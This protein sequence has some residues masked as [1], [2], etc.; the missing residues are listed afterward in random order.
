MIQFLRTFSFSVL[1][2]SILAF[3]QISCDSYE[4]RSLLYQVLRKL[5]FRVGKISTEYPIRPDK[6]DILFL[7]NLNE[8]L[9]KKGREQI[10][11]FVEDGG[12]LIVTANSLGAD[13]LFRDYQLALRSL[14]DYIAFA[15][16][17]PDEPFF[18]SLPVDDIRAHTS[19]A[20]DPLAREV[21][22][23]YGESDRYVMVTFCEGAGR[24]YFISST[25]LFGDA[26][27]SFDENA[28]L[29]YNLVSTF[30]RKA[31]I[32]LTETPD[33][34]FTNDQS[35]PNRGNFMA[36][37]FKTPAGLGVIY[38]CLAL[39]IFLTLRGRRFGKPLQVQEKNRRLSTEYVLAMTA[40]YQK[41]NTRM[42]ILKQLRDKFKHDLAERWRVN[43]NLEAAAFIE[44]LVQRGATDEEGQISKLLA[45]LETKQDISEV[46]LLEIA[47]RVETY[48]ETE[49]IGRSK[50]TTEA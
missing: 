46:Q 6:F 19:F 25:Y 31:R 14:T 10:H 38:I 23:L 41:G 22:P 43:P 42:E 44:E 40:L 30:P 47:Q 18:P 3:S 50:F 15:Q 33:Y 32:G 34:R 7:Q 8:S 1:L 27:L 35:E 21:A 11:E 45:E 12:I 36:F 17:I 37:L 28:K 9:S 16:R 49:R 20:I 29:L 39:F 26:G 24:A 2:G 13:T 48:C 5:N 4:N